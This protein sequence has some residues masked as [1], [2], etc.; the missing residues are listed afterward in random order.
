MRRAEVL[1]VGGGPGGAACALR[2]RQHGVDC[3]VLDQRDFPRLKPCA[4]WI[5]P[6]V[7]KD[8]QISPADYPHGLVTFRSFEIG[9][10]RFHFR[11]RTHQHAIRRIEF[12]H[13]LLQRSGAP[14]ATHTVRAITRTASGYDIDGEFEGKFLVGAGGTY[15]PVYR[16]LFKDDHP[17]ERGALIAAMEEEFAYPGADQRCYL[18]FLE[19]GLPGY[20]WY[21][22]KGGGYVNVGIGG[23]GEAMKSGLA[24]RQHWDILIQKLEKMGLVQGHNYQPVAHSYYLR[25]RLV[26]VHKENAFLVGDAAGLATTDMGEGIGAAIRSGLLAANAI[27]N[28]AEYS[29]RSIPQHSFVSILRSGFFR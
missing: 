6:E 27:A 10:R 8:L 13:W 16:S 29:L 28:G 15:C 22:P 18:W 24:L 1:I 9:V 17:R 25:Q 7:L 23:V 3:L 11:L 4:G 2:L 5:T 14:V 19:N 20:S 21:V 26:G 12:D